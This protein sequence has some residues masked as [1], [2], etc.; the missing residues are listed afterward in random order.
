[1]TDRFS[2]DLA[3][4]LRAVRDDRGLSVNRLAE[5]SGVS[6]AMITK[7]EGGQAQPTA[8]LLG[9]LCAALGLTLSELFAR[10]EGQAPRLT[11]AADQ[12]V[13]VDPATG[14]RRRSVSP[15]GGPVELVEVELPAGAE[16]SYPA[17][18]YALAGHQIWVLRG[19]LEFR[20]GD[21]EHDLRAGDCLELGA[22]APGTY[23]NTSDE[24]CRYLV[25]LS[26]PVR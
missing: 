6:R 5:L 25:V 2:A 16:V 1:M 24:P 14:Y 19:R 10:T 18:S 3:T 9:R 26:R 8:A 21:V 23:R 11:R 20:E 15:A 13:W 17:E 22:P 4:T 7:I 12:L